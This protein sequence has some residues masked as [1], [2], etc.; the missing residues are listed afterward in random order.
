MSFMISALVLLLLNEPRI[1]ADV[2]YATVAG[3]ELKLDLYHPPSDAPKTNAAVVVIHGGAWMS[4][5]RKQMKDLSIQLAK[6]GML[7]ASVQYR[8]APKAVWPAMLDDVQTATRY[9]RAN[10]AKLGFDPNRLGA[11]GASAGGHLA[12]FLGSRDTR[13]AKPAHFGDQSSRV[14]AVLN[15]FGPTDM[16]RDFPANL[17]VMFQLVLGKPRAQAAQEIRDASPINFIDKNSAPMFIY[18]GLA[19]PLVNPNQ[20]RYLEAKLKEVAVPVQAV[21]LKDVQHNVPMTNPKVREAMEQGI[22]WLVAHLTKR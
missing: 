7:A 18:Q 13:D 17:D 10:A 1:E 8:L 2:T 16:S 5:D 9:L 21:Y 4:G 14:H 20:S 12:I 6:R 19:D 11:A 22:E 15:L 3:T